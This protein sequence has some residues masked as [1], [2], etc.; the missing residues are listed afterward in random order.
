MARMLAPISIVMYEEMAT[1]VREVAD[2]EGISIAQVIRECI[3]VSL[4]DREIRKGADV[5]A[6]LGAT[7]ETPKD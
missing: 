1:R 4:Y 3:A 2:S 6:M 7:S 5:W